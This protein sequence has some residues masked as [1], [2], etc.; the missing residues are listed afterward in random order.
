MSKLSE[1][2]EKFCRNI[3][4]G[5]NQ[6]DA[7][8]E[9]GYKC[10]N[11]ETAWACSSRLLGNAK[12]AKRI[13]ALRKDAEAVSTFTAAAFAKRLDRLARAAENTAL[14]ASVSD[15]GVTTEL[16]AAKAAAD[17]ARQS[18]MDAAKLLGLV[19][20]RSKVESENVNFN[21]SDKPMT[22]EQWESEFADANPVEASTGAATR[23]N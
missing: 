19:V 20:D 18:M 7:Y 4:E 3:V 14:K 23:L 21:V 10:A 6:G 12:V 8:R 17:V 2:Q 22:E 13:A 11:D 1:Q 9:A 15:E 5:M 16:I